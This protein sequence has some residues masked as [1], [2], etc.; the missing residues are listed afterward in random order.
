MTNDFSHDELRRDVRETDEMNRLAMPNWRA[1]LQRVFESEP[2]PDAKARLALGF[3]RRTLLRVGGLT[4]IGGAVL[5]ACGSSKGSGSA[6]TA[7]TTAAGAATTTTAAMGTMT[8]DVTI[9]R[10]ASSIEELAVAA[11]QTA[12]DSGLVKTAAIGDAAKAF[13]AQHKEHSA[14][15]QSLTTKAGGQAFTMANPAILAAIQPQ[16]AALKDEMGVVALALE[17]EMVAAQTYQANVGNFTDMTLNAA[18]MSVGGVE[19]RHAAILAGVLG[20]AP[21]TK[22]FQVTDSATKPGTGVS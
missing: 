18:I 15:F 16:I 9:L 14:L 10:T 11:Y 6:T 17:L 22:A 7:G 4:I 3:D 8:E 20:Q 19:A 2:N 21:V 12:I 1:A 5:A 13:Q